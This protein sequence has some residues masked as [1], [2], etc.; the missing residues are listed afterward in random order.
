[1]IRVIVSSNPD[2][3]RWV[4]NLHR[5]MPVGYGRFLDIVLTRNFEVSAI[6]EGMRAGYEKFLF[7]QD[8]CVVKDHK[9]LEIAAGYDTALLIPRPNCYLAV[10]HTR[11]LR[12][13]WWPDIDPDD[14][15]SSIRYETEWMDSYE[16]V[17]RREFNIPSVPVI[18]PQITD[19][20]ALAEENFLEVNG[21]R[22]LVLE[23]E[24]FAKYK[25]T[26]R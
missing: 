15:E 20:R 18:F 7:L 2:R 17:A 10:Y 14:K 11:V 19:G 24:Y 25:G 5:A 13:M 9:L 23:N 12:Q 4:D 26:F 22:R 16:E 21:E 1:M 6:R 3:Q 8:S